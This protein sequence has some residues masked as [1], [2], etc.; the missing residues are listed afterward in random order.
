[1]SVVTG[2]SALSPVSEAVMD[3]LG[4]EAFSGASGVCPGGVWDVVP[5]D[6]PFPYAWFLVSEVPDRTYGRFGQVLEVQLHVFT[7]A[8]GMRSGQLIMATAISLLNA[9]APSVTG[10][11]FQYLDHLGTVPMATFLVDN[12]RTYDL[13]ARFEVLVMETD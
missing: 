1:M 2:K 10:F 6:Q 13:Q 12:I 11:A 8:D 7:Q 4:I 9:S 3:V 5:P